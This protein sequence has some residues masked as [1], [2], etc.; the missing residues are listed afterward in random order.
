MLRGDPT[1]MTLRELL[2]SRLLYTASKWY[3]YNPTNG[4]Y[5]KKNVIKLISAIRELELS[6][7]LNLRSMK[8]LLTKLK[9][10]CTKQVSFD[11][12]PHLLAYPNGVLDLRTSEFRAGTREEYLVSILS[13]SL[14]GST[15]NH[16]VTIHYGPTASNGKSFLHQQLSE[17]LGDYGGCILPQY[18]TA[19]A[20]ARYSERHIYCQETLQKVKPVDGNLH[21]LCNVFPKFSSS[22]DMASVRVIEYKTMFVNKPSQPHHRQIKHFSPEETH[23]LQ[24]GLLL[25]LTVRLSQLRQCG[26]VIKIPSTFSTYRYL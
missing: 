13:L 22:T 12:H 11:T 2:Q 23:E 5:E 19:S 14:E 25:L 17:A 6:E 1:H 8:Q 10:I 3:L 15:R 9:T 21:L 24:S 26:F 20:L 7:E 18:P 16:S 4:L